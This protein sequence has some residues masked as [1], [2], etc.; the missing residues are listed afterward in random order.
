M[1]ELKSHIFPELANNY[2]DQN[3]LASR[4]ILACKNDAVQEI[5]SELLMSLPGIAKIYK[6][7]DTFL[8][9]Q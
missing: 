1:L 8:D 4:V 7:F 3:W 6:S 2:K 5:N 9:V